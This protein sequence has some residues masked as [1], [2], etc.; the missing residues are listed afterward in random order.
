M[1]HLAH[2]SNAA[3]ALIMIATSF[4]AAAQTAVD[5]DRSV[6]A[7]MRQMQ[8]ELDA[9]R[10]DNQAMKGQID[11]LKSRTEDNWLTETRANEIRGLVQDVLA[12]ADTRASLLQNGASAGWSDHFFLGS[13]DGRFLL[14]L[15]GQEQ[16]RWIYNYHE[17]PKLPLAQGTDFRSH[18]HGFEVARSRLTFRGHVFSPDLEYFI[19][20]DFYGARQAPNPVAPGF[21]FL[22]DAW[23]RYNLTDEWSVKV[24]QFKIPFNREEL[25]SSAEQLAVERSLANELLNLGRSQGVELD[26]HDDDNAFSAAYTD[27]AT[28]SFLN[29]NQQ[30]VPWNTFN[31]NNPNAGTDYAFAA[32]FERKIAGTWEQFNDFTSP[33][34]D[35]FAMM[36][37]LGGQVQRGENNG[38]P[39]ATPNELGSVGATADLSVEWGGAN[40]FAAFI[41]QY[42]DNPPGAPVKFYGIVVQGGIY[43]APKWEVFARAEYG[44]IDASASI[45]DLSVVT[46]GVNY[47][48][49]GHDVK[50]TTDIGVALNPLQAPWVND[51]AGYRSD[52]VNNLFGQTAHADLQVV[53]RTQLQLLF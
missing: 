17:L 25:V 42:A 53:F 4:P 51:F 23:I 27:G 8:Q 12:D 26:Y 37:G 39:S 29:T 44:W 46:A 11:D 13:P 47:Y 34:G 33:V 28:A 45:E 36:V 40:A 15:E 1:R 18:R 43:V 21:A 50:W 2:S 19:R 14:I 3:V 30:N 5:P 9:L 35:Q 22:L 24:G 41:W 20:G 7:Q 16:V 31:P 52:F 10:R 6:D 38:A 49:D 48:I 32:R